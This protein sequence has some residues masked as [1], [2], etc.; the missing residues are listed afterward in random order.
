MVTKCAIGLLLGA[1]LVVA[2]TPLERAEDAQKRDDFETAAREF[3]RALELNPS[4]AETH[5]RLGMVYRR[6]RMLPEAIA[7]ME[8]ALRLDPTLP[9]LKILL[10]ISFHEAGRCRDA[11]PLLSES[12][13]TEREPRM[14]S[15]AGQ[16]LAECYLMISDTQTALPVIQLLRKDFADDPAILRLALQVYMSLWNNAYQEMMT[17]APGSVQARQILAE[18]LEAQERF[19]EAAAEYEQI[20]KIEPGHPG[21][22][23][24]LGRM[25]LRAEATAAGLD[26]AAA[27]FRKELEIRPGHVGSMIE[28]GEIEFKKGRLADASAAFSQAL[29][30]E[31]GS[32][33]ARLGLAKVRIAE[34]Q[35]AKALEQLEMVRKVAPEDEAMAYNL[36]ITY[37]ALGRTEEAKAAFELV[38]RLKKRRQRK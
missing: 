23:Y 5:G 11:I 13:Q 2:Q 22:H 15:V 9:R 7:S 25:L 14:R 30:I 3:R 29:G 27:E 26:K 33:P 8:T 28:I 35:W 20:L 31:A 16:R 10:G 4:D 24:Q 36:M 34:K 21:I 37:R 32:M 19:R 18:G 6:M 12:F 1:A 38:E 17:K